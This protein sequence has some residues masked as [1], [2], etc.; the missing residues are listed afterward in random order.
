MKKLVLRGSDARL[1]ALD[2][3]GVLHG[4]AGFDVLVRAG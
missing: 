2:F 1:G 3:P 4:S